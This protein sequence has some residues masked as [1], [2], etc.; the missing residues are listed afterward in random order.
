MRMVEEWGGIASMA[1]NKQLLS[2]KTV[3]SRTTAK[4]KMRIGGREGS[5]AVHAIQHGRASTT[6]GHGKHHGR[7]V[8]VA[9][10]GSLHFASLRR[11][12][13]FLA[14]GNCYGVSV[15]GHFGPS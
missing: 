13:L 2:H 4:E 15:L 12:L 11:R 10:L 3:K 8:V 5:T 7:P 1:E 6:K 9:V 14:H